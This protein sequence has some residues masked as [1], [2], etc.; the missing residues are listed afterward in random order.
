MTCRTPIIFYLVASET[1]FSFLS[2]A[3][4]VTR[5]E[6]SRVAKLPSLHHHIVRFRCAPVVRMRKSGKYEWREQIRDTIFLLWLPELGLD[7]RLDEIDSPSA[8]G[9]RRP[10]KLRSIALERGDGV[11]ARICFTSVARTP[12]QLRSFTV[13]RTPLR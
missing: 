12:L 3:A 8:T 7:R 11:G 6:R 5:D 13:E 2:N 9:A 10:R 4:R 1:H